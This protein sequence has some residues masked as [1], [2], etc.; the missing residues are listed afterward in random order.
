MADYLSRCACGGRKPARI[1][2]S[3]Y[4]PRNNLIS[5]LIK[6]RHLIR[7][8]VAPAT[9]GKSFIAFEYAEEVFSFNHVYWLDG[10]SPCF[11][12]DL[13]D[14]SLARSLVKHKKGKPALVVIEDIPYLHEDRAATFLDL[15]SEA[16]VLGW[17][18]VITMVPGCDV[19]RRD[20]KS[21]HRMYSQDILLNDEDI[22]LHRTMIEIERR[23]AQAFEI[24]ERIA[25]Q[26][27]GR[28]VV[29]GDVIRNV[30]TE[31]LTKGSLLAVFIML[32][33]RQGTF[34]DVAQF[35]RTK[36]TEVIL[37]ELLHYSYLQIDSCQESF[38]AI[39]L[40]M[41]SIA[42]V[43]AAH[44]E[45]LFLYS[46]FP[47][48]DALILRL[49]DALLGRG[50]AERACSLM[51]LLA[52]SAHR[53]L[54]LQERNDLLFA[55]GCLLPAYNL[56]ESIGTAKIVARNYLEIANALRLLVLRKNEK[57]VQL[58][59]RVF[60]ARS[61][62]QSCRVS[63]AL[64]VNAFDDER[65]HQSEKK[66]LES[67]RIEHDE[68]ISERD[69][70]ADFLIKMSSLLRI[71]RFGGL[72]NENPQTALTFLQECAK[73]EPC[74]QIIGVMIL[75]YL[76]SLEKDFENRARMKQYFK[77]NPLFVRET[78]LY[79]KGRK[80]LEL[81]GLVE[82][83]ILQALKKSDTLQTK[84]EF[85]SFDFS[86]VQQAQDMELSLFQ[87]EIAYE[88]QLKEKEEKREE[89]KKMNPDIFRFGDTGVS[90]RRGK[91]TPTLT[92][93]LLGGLDVRI[94]EEV[95]EP[96]RFGR[97]KVKALLAL[98]ILNRGKEVSRDRLMST[99]WPDSNPSAARRNL[100]ATWSILR[101]SLAI[102]GGSCP[103]LIRTQ[104]CY[105]I[106]RQY[107]K[108]DVYEFDELCR[109][110][111]FGVPD[112]LEWSQL[113]ARSSQIY[114]GDLL[115]TET[116]NHAILKAREDY[117]T[118]FVDSFAVAAKKL[119]E[120]HQYDLAAWFAQDAVEQ[121]PTRE[122]AYSIMME[123]QIACGRRTAAMATYF[124]CR[125]YLSE[126]LG[127][128][129]SAHIKLL[130]QNILE[131]DSELKEEFDVNLEGD[132]SD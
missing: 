83:L 74:G 68:D 57:A 21:I 15:M 127:L 29:P 107:V 90:L 103:Y 80:Q 97:Q 65:T 91:K 24:H 132:E 72:L 54:W 13:D 114:R 116:K 45:I 46:S 105:K 2:A 3:S 31:E 118:K 41:E 34:D 125:K 119:F 48:K 67:L 84:D 89:F 61:A 106:E 120:I 36:T 1:K 35:V 27:W 40:E 129:P 66:Y 25:G 7:M 6:Y 121:D 19:F 123:S 95:I 85:D 64:I 108:S 43:F 51:K 38:N 56:F 17:E 63:A 131:E 52:T 104:L 12:R 92:V 71:I 9:F 53:A 59:D 62:D 11:L 88:I 44:L 115:P 87:Q 16:L 78:F 70:N 5:Q 28:G 82:C 32:V 75:R 122:D 55:K 124:E 112:A 110:F 93:D 102:E 73:S 18:I 79:L 37:K 128:D 4:Y 94:G 81:F 26:Y 8:I 50:E 109:T 58:A 111:L 49:A 47:S 96:Q 22:D 77:S 117:R 33:L 100:H 60:Q 101:R 76:M 69:N 99:L 30:A 130:Y 10:K 23:P 20:Q 39:S 113:Y 98:L 42:A 14:G 86:L 126:E